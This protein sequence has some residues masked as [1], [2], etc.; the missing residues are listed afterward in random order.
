MAILQSSY[1]M[2]RTHILKKMPFLILNKAPH[3]HRCERTNV[4]EDGDH[5]SKTIEDGNSG[6]PITLRPT[7]GHKR[8]NLISIRSDTDLSKNLFNQQVPSEVYYIDLKRG[9][10]NCFLKNAFLFLSIRLIE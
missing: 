9:I 4:A 10:K 2:D 1:K 5:L 6:S 8:L 3:S 7:V